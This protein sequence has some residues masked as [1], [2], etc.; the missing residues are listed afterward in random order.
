M[1]NSAE[2]MRFLDFLIR[3][4]IRSVILHEAG[5]P[6]TVPAPERFAIHKLIVSERRGPTS[7]K[8][9]KDVAQSSLLI[10]AMWE[11]RAVDLSSAWQEAWERGP[12]WRQAL[13]SGLARLDEPIAGKLETAVKAGAVKRRVAVHWP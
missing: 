10:E 2:P 9:D 7:S 8:V 13:T 1:R 12:T 6:V 5:V 3:N 4:P 11:R